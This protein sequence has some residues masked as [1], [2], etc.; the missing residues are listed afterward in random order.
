MYFCQGSFCILSF[1]EHFYFF[2]KIFHRNPH[3]ILD[4]G[5]LLTSLHDDIYHPLLM[6]RVFHHITNLL[7]VPRQIVF[8]EYVDIKLGQ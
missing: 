6:M 5:D 7:T 2:K 1:S 3:V 8:L 4:F